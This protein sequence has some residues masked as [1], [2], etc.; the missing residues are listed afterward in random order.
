MGKEQS[1]KAIIYLVLA[2]LCILTVYFGYQINIIQDNLKQYVT[3]TA[4]DLKILQD[5]EFD[6]SLVINQIRLKTNN[7]QMQISDLWLRTVNESTQDKIEL[8]GR[9][10]EDEMECYVDSDFRITISKNYYDYIS[11]YGAYFISSF[12]TGDLVIRDDGEISCYRYPIQSRKPEPVDCK[13]LC[14]IDEQEKSLMEKELCEDGGEL[15]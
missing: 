3:A 5:R 14:K 15:C 10:M 8:F 4:S 2:V 9:F 7:I 13:F 11:G 12:K 1:D 6:N